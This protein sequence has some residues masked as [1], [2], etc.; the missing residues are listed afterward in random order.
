MG[1][2]PPVP[3]T[4]PP[5]VPAPSHRAVWGRL[6][7]LAF[8]LIALYV[9]WPSLLKVFSAWPELLR[10]APEWFV[11]MLGLEVASFVCIWGLQRIA[12]RTRSWFGVA[13]AQLT[14]NAV[15]RVVP[16]GAAAGGAVQFGILVAEG[17]EPAQVGTG[18]MV[19]S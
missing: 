1:T 17:V 2:S 13:T 4:P 11:V 14:G 6:I 16:G 3:P 19:A 5:N 9:L 15:S 7:F 12:L 8:T 10:I 18:L